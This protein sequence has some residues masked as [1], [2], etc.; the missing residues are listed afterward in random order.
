MIATAGN[1]YGN[2]AISMKRL[3]GERVQVEWDGYMVANYKKR[4]KRSSNQQTGKSAARRP[5]NASSTPP[6]YSCLARTSS[7]S[8]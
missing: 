2:K 3:L 5:D 8:R 6:Q 4:E 1:E 7:R